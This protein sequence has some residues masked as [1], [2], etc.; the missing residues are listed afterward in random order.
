MWIVRVDPW[1]TPRWTMFWR[2]CRRRVP[3]FTFPGLTYYGSALY[4]SP[5]MSKTHYKN[6]F[7]KAP[8]P[9]IAHSKKVLY[10]EIHLSKNSLHLKWQYR[11]GVFIKFCFFCHYKIV[12]TIQQ[13]IPT[14]ASVQRMTRM[15]LFKRTRF[16]KNCIILYL[17]SNKLSP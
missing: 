17:F 12:G 13:S 16:E 9:W 3:G 7:R 15:I 6:L 11:A 1:L 14:H 8:G 5:S 10:P 4:A 2:D